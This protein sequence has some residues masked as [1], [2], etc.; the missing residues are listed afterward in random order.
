VAA[1]EQK[2][3]TGAHGPAEQKIRNNAAGQ[4]E[5]NVVPQPRALRRLVK[6][7]AVNPAGERSVDLLIHK[8]TLIL[9]KPGE[10]SSRASSRS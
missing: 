3:E 5:L 8:R 1:P 6:L 9:G 7:M 2:P 4:A 10:R